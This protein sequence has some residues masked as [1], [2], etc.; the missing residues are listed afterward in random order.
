MPRACHRFTLQA[1]Q[2]RPKATVLR[3]ALKWRH[4][5]KAVTALE[6]VEYRFHRVADHESPDGGR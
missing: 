3:A 4:A 1:M 6:R 2:A 5:V